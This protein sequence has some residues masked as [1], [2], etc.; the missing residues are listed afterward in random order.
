MIPE[1]PW[2]FI[3]SC[4]GQ[5]TSGTL[6]VRNA[7]E[8]QTHK[9]ADHLPHWLFHRKCA[10]RSTQRH[11]KVTS[12]GG[13]RLT[14]RESQW[15][16]C[17]DH[18]AWRGMTRMRSAFFSGSFL[19]FV[20]KLT[21]GRSSLLEARL[22]E[23]WMGNKDFCSPPPGSEVSQDQSPPSPAGSKKS[24]CGLRTPGSFTQS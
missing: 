3:T 18:Y 2:F 13:K 4:H 10:V 11:A 9:P 19:L 21:W 17:R 20:L 23:P 1:T 6:A 8:R 7:R 5:L 16:H 12:P 24:E 14:S 15:T 22:E